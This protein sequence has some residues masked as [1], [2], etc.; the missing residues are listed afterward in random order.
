MTKTTTFFIRTFSCFILIFL[1]NTGVHSSS[2]AAFMKANQLYSL[3]SSDQAIDH[4]ICEGY[5]IGI[6][7]SI[8]SG[9]LGN[10]FQVCYPEGISITQLR[11]VMVNYMETI[12]EKLHFVADG[13]VGEGLATV[14]QC[15]SN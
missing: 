2:S 4:S 8:F 9:H 12:P 14:F 10:I 3:C 6:N 5:I 13:I 15:Q 1:L 7:D 11:L